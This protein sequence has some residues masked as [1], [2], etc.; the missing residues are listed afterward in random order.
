MEALYKINNI[1]R[2]SHYKAILRIKELNER[3]FLYINFIEEVRSIHPGMGLRTM[4]EYHQPEGV[5]R[6]EFIEIGVSAGLVVEPK[7]SVPKTTKRHPSAIYP[8]LL[9][10]KKFTDVNQ[11]WTSD[12]TYFR[13]GDRFYYLTFIL[14]VYSRRIVGYSVA[15]NMRAENNVTALKMALKLRRIKD[16]NNKLIHHS[17]RGSQY[18]SEAYV[19]LLS[20][21]NIS[22]SMC[23][24]VLENSHVERINGTI[25]NQYL[26]HWPINNYNDLKYYA[27]KAVTAYNNKPHK[28]L[29]KK[30]P[31]EFE[32]YVK[33][34]SVQNRYEL[35]MFVY[36]Q[37]SE[38]M[39]SN[40]LL[41]K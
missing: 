12:I 36:Q 23:N 8:N 9:L 25:K 20:R 32:N 13:I 21:S 7:A 37:K 1:S 41:L 19:G 30:T 38:T 31:I 10:E 14:D 40:P 39:D 26:K 29:N 22:I 6:D 27:L 34:L 3:A 16:Y 35:E 28:A 18:I 17:D 2:Q 33:D 15:D 5:G 4:Y 24:N 11:I